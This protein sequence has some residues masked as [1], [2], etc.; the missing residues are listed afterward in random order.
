MNRKRTSIATAALV[1]QLGATFVFAATD[2]GDTTNHLT[3]SA[4][5]CCV[6]DGRRSPE[7]P[8]AAKGML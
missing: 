3:F 2:Y 4:S 1:S 5:V 6:E 8:K 7:L